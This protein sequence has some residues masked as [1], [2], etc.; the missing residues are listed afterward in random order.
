MK[1]MRAVAEARAEFTSAAAYYEEQQRG[2][3]R[4]F[5]AAVDDALRRINRDPLLY[6]I[7]E[8]G[9]RRCRVHRFP[10]AVVYRIISGDIEVLA[11]AHSAREPG[12][13]RERIE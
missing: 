12:Y 6:R 10:F 7:A 5:I 4:R 2:L 1:Q 9:V 3:A 13:W 8:D 11:V